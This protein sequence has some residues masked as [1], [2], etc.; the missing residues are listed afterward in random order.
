M[1]LLVRQYSELLR[2]TTWR[3]DL[4]VFL[5]GQDAGELRGD[6]E[7][8]CSLYHPLITQAG[9]ATPLD[10]T[11][12]GNSGRDVWSL[13]HT[14]GGSIRPPAY[15]PAFARGDASVGDERSRSF[16]ETRYCRPVLLTIYYVWHLARILPSREELMP[17]PTPRPSVDR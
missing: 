10:P 11:H 4:S 8:A 17:L 3:V 1:T 2:V 7:G 13:T 9:M 12:R 15:V 5:R 16:L 14:V 6:V